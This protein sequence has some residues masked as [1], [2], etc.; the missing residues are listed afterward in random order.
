[1]KWS[2][3]QYLSKF[4]MLK[5]KP[6]DLNKGFLRVRTRLSNITLLFIL[7]MLTCHQCWV[8]NHEWNPDTLGTAFFATPSDVYGR[9]VPDC[10]KPFG[11]IHFVGSERST[12]GTQWMD[13][14]VNIGQK[15]AP[16]VVRALYPNKFGDAQ[17]EQYK[18]RI[19]QSEDQAVALLRKTLTHHGVLYMFEMI[20]RFG[21]SVLKNAIQYL[22]AKHGSYISYY[23]MLSVSLIPSFQ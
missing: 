6:E 21:K 3:F 7:T 10:A 1:M 2:A 8:W 19:Q 11:L 14:A 4:G 20:G 15:K 9:N 12:R 17:H 16:E 5:K 13:G 23:H 22:K 18:D